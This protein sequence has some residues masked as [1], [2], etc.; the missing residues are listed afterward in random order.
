MKV[1]LT[2]A[3]SF[4]GYWFAEKLAAA[5]ATIV[6]PLRG[7]PQS[8]SGVRA[9]RV[10]QLSSVAEIVSETSFGDDRFLALAGQRDFD[11]FCHHAARVADYRSLDFDVAA[12]VAENTRHFRGMLERM[13][14]RG[15]RAVVATGSV[16][17]Q[18]E[19]AGNSPLRAFSPYGLSKGLT[20]QI[21]RHWCIHFGL[22]LGKFVIANPFGP[23]EEPRFVAH[24]VNCW[25]RGDIAEVRTPRYLR[26]N[27]HVDLL[28][29]AYARF[30]RE[31]VM[32]GRGGRLGPC[33]Y[34][35]TQGSFAER[36]ANE[37]GPRLGFD[38]RVNLLSQTDFSEPLARINTDMI[39]PGGYGW[40]EA[41]A[42]DALAH[43]YRPTS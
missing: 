33:G 22:P 12:A 2:G 26:D 24:L 14:A 29:F 37:L 31:T 38:C 4:S 28:A 23:L 19:G 15:L 36:A 17:E 35:E 43:Y 8:Y 5:G 16:F 25:R 20:W 9:E 39:E 1:L 42:W 13:T 18:D 41:A 21:I 27:I 34:L 32:G 7:S 40:S 3:S 6:A 11:V 30:V 10:R